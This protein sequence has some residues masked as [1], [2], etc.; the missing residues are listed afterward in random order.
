MDVQTILLAMSLPSAITGF[1][2]WLL[3]RKLMKGQKAEEKKDEA[4]RQ[5][6]AIVI[7]GVMAAITLGE[8][9][10]KAVQR[11]PDAHC[12]GDMHDALT[13]ATKVKIKHRDFIREQGI[14]ALY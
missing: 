13:Y 11:I 3:E 2:F 1:C 7:E 6:E 4:R 10:A 8:A 14:D 9:T 5:N 12:N